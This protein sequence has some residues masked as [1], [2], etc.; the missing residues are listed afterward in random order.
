MTIPSI[1]IAD[2]VAEHLALSELDHLQD[3]GEE[4][5]DAERDAPM[6]EGDEAAQ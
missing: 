6:S 5:A 3:I 4:R 1:R 2:A